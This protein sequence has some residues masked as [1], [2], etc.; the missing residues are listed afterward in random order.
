[1]KRPVVYIITNFHNTTL[2]IGVTSDLGKRMYQHKDKLVQGFSCKYNLTKLVYYEQ[3]ECIE[4]AIMREK[5]L[6]RWRR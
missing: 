1:M 5:R 4:N 6:K 2:Y 3:F